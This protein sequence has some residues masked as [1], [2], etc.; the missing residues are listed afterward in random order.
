MAIKRFA[1][2]KFSG[3]STD[4]KPANVLIGATFW[5]TNT[6]LVY[7]YDGDDW[8]EIGYVKPA[9][10]SLV[11][12]SNDYNDLDN[13]PDLTALETKFEQ[14]ANFA[15]FP[16]TGENDVL[17]VAQDTGYLY[18]WTGSEYTQLTDQTAVWGSISGT[19]SD[20]TDLNNALND[21]VLEANKASTAE[22]EAG[23]D[24]TKWMTPLKTK[25][26][27]D[28]FASDSGEANTASNVG[29]GSGVF[30]EKAGVDL[31]FKSLVGGDNIT[32]DT[33]DPDEIKIDASGGAEAAGAAGDV[34]FNDGSDNLAADAALNYDN[35][36]KEL[37]IPD[38][39]ITE[40]GENNTASGNDNV[41]I[42]VTTEDVSGDTVVRFMANLGNGQDVIIAS[43]IDPA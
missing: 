28:E 15:A 2:D 5:E 27:I 13:L 16:A 36:N 22:A 34:Q 7:Q 8:E 42:K 29:A 20:Q 26:A 24:D 10:L 30:K 21:R 25:Q 6:S 11:A 9:D 33:T 43:Y 35:T 18:R 39:R 17:Y 40:S 3:L 12:T 19:L 31:R 1:G 41:V 23:T 4:T 37:S 14:Y 32:L 38:L